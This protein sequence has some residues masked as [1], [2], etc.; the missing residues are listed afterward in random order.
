MTFCRNTLL[1]FL[2]LASSVN[3]FSLQQRWRQ[4]KIRKE[5]PTSLASSPSAVIGTDSSLATTTPKRY[6]DQ[7]GP[8]AS[9]LTKIGMISFIAS[10][11]IALPVTLFPLWALYKVGLLSKVR[12]ERY[13]LK[14]GQFCA[15]WLM[16]LIPFCRVKVTPFRD[17]SPEPSIWA[18]NHV[19][20]LDIFVLLAHDLQARGKHK[21]PIKIV[22]WKQLEDNPVTKLLFQQSGFIPVQMTANKAG[23]SN[24]YDM[25]SFKLLLKEAKRAFEE[26]FDVG[27]LPEGQLNP[28]PEEGLLPC[29]SGAFTLARM[30]KRPIQFMALQG[31]HRLW[32]ADEDIGMACTGRDIKLRVFPSARKYSSA[33]EFL[34]TFQ[35]VVGNFGT[36]G[37]DVGADSSSSGESNAILN[38]WLDG[39]KWKE[40]QAAEENAKEKD[41]NDSK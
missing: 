41:G 39:S 13:A 37:Y 29:F 20:G 10:M 14:T 25:K 3:G 15:R 1:V 17:S 21:R 32:H 23:E 26:G 6:E 5:M 4:V 40:M 34:A 35:A 19:S 24:D 27:I 16:R 11:C 9:M 30:S 18:C 31:T 33:D 38:A 8:V 12:K 22:Y 7:L 28:H 2:L 36:T